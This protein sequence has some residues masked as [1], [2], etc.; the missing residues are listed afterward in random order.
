MFV[1]VCECARVSVFHD[2]SH[3]IKNIS[4]KVK[5][6]LNLSVRRTM[7]MPSLSAAAACH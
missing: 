7:M 2:V 4:V 6:D 5:Q 3:V 1:C